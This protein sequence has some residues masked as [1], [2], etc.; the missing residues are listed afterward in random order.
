[1]VKDPSVPK[2][3]GIVMQEPEE[4]T[5]R[6]T[7]VPSQGSKDKDKAKMIK[8]DKPL[9]K[10]NQIMIDEDVGR[11]L[12]AQLQAELEEEERL[13]GQKEKEANIALIVEWDD[14]QAMMDAD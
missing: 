5:I 3:K 14:V 2:A 12:K 1:M 7:I 10:K 13:A 8:P 11:N 9:K 4:K 6:T